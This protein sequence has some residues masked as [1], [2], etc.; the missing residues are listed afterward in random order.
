MSVGVFVVRP[1]LH[2]VGHEFKLRGQ[3]NMFSGVWQLVDL[4]FCGQFP[5]LSSHARM[6]SGSL[7]IFI[8]SL[9]RNTFGELSVFA[10]VQKEESNTID[11]AKKV[12]VLFKAM[13][14]K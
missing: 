10:Y 6:F 7:Q 5:S 13:I 2:S 9:L 1:Y 14:Y 8:I 11:K 12:I 3:A 4:H